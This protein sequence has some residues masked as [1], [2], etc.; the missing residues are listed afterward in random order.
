MAQFVARYPVV[1]Y[2]VIGLWLLGL[3]LIAFAGVLLNGRPDRLSLVRRVS[4]RLPTSR[5]AQRSTLR[6]IVTL[7]AV[8]VAGAAVTVLIMLGLGAAWVVHHGS[9]IDQPIYRF[10]IHHQVHDWVRVMAHLTRVGNTWTTWGAALTAAAVLAAFWPQGRKWIPPVILAS[11]IVVDHYAT[12]GLRHVFERVGPPN[13]PHGTYPSGGCERVILFYG[14]ISYL[15]WREASG[16]RTS[17]IWA[18]VGVAMLAFNEAYSRSYLTLHWFTDAV[19]GL[20]YGG[21]MLVAFAIAVRIVAGPV[22]RADDRILM[23]LPRRSPEP[24][25]APTG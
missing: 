21:L 23:P 18:G 25:L 5:R 13:S 19:S 24:D 11:A 17:G 6:G 14:L 10:T 16:R 8:S 1:R 20:L 2:M 22:R 3:A 12:I 4:D 9:S 7:V 15:T